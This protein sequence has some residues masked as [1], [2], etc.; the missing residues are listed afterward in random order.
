MVHAKIV[1][2][3]HAGNGEVGQGPHVVVL[4]A[5]AEENLLGPPTDNTHQGIGPLLVG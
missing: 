3:H 2:L 5:V 1:L 4:A